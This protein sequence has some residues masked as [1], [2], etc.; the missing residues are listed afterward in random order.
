M[1]FRDLV[2]LFRIKKPVGTVLLFLPCLWGLI[3]GYECFPPV[4]DLIL[5]GVGAFCMRSAG[6]AYNDWV[7]RNIDGKVSR[8]KARP[9][10]VRRVSV[11]QALVPVSFFLCVALGVLLSLRGYAVQIG[12]IVAPAILP[13][14]W[15]KRFANWPQLYLGFLFGSGLLMAFA[16]ASPAG[17]PFP[18]GIWFFY[19]AGALWTLYYDTLYAY[20]DRH[21]DM[22]MGLGSTAV[23]FKDKPH[24]FLVFLVIL[25]LS[26]LGLGGIWCDLQGGFFMGLLGVGLHFSWQLRTLDLKRP[27]TFGQTFLSNQWTGLLIVLCFLLGVT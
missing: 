18:L 26:L 10:A 12:L 22:K 14:P 1:P 16:H 17:F 19:G 5:F 8:T 13:Y 6:C 9:L 11:F 3:L 24:E 23:F 25:I 15:L 27:K 2:A 7:D 21:D 20:Q 4:L